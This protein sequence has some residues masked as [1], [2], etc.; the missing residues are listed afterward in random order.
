MYAVQTFYYDAQSL[1][2]C[3]S[4][5]CV[6]MLCRKVT[7]LPVKNQDTALFFYSFN[8]N[9]LFRLFFV[10]IVGYVRTYHL[11][12]GSLKTIGQLKVSISLSRAA[13]YV[14]TKLLC[15]AC[16]RIPLIR[17][18]NVRKFYHDGTVATENFFVLTLSDLPPSSHFRLFMR[19]MLKNEC[20]C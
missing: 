19:K 14:A 5:S 3:F 15:L 12:G 16:C 1:K 7:L 9:R 17:L 8:L 10:G 18:I 2:I 11:Q 13:W 6:F 4:Y 20:S